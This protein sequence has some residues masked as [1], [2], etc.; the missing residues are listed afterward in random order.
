MRPK[1]HTEKHIVQSSLFAVAAAAITR[2]NIVKGLQAPVAATATNVREGST[3]S[4]VYVEM[5]LT[6]DDAVASTCIAT[7]EKSIAGGTAMTVAQSASLDSYPNKRNIFHTFQGLLPPNTQYPMAAVKGWFKIPKG[8][9]RFGIDDRLVLNI[10]GQS[11]G[12]TGCG[13][14]IFKE[15]Y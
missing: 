7:L 15:Q 14:F 8:K 12:V 11:D 4:A 5:W 10:H 13:F 3:I 6:G 9:Q 1:V 2:I